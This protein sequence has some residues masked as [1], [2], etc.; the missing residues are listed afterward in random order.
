MKQAAD[1]EH[2]PFGQ[3][4][5]VEREKEAE[6]EQKAV[7]RQTAKQAQFVSQKRRYISFLLTS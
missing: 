4:A 6:M 2:N 5:N 7:K 3:W 1:E